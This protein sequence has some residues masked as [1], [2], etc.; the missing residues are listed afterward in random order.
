MVCMEENVREQKDHNPGEKLHLLFWNL[1]C[2]QYVGTDRGRYLVHVHL[3]S[4]IG[5]SKAGK[6]EHYYNLMEQ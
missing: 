5:L 4:I 1:W 6:S 3:P 2:Y